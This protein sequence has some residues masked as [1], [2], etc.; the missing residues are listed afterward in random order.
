MVAGAK[1]SLKFQF[2][3][4][5]GAGNGGHPFEEGRMDVRLFSGLLHLCNRKKA[6]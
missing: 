4:Q 2:N 5:F 1:P 3:I 6:R